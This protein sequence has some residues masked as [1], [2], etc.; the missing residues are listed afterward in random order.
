MV[1]SNNYALTSCQG[2]PELQTPIS[3]LLS[4]KCATCSLTSILI[5]RKQIASFKRS[6]WDFLA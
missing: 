3:A 2:N 5:H 1:P 6:E 4:Q